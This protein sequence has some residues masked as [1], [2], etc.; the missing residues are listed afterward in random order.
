MAEAAYILLAESGE[1]DAHEKIRKCTLSCE[2]NKT[3]LKEELEKDPALWT[4][5]A[6]GLSKSLA[7]S[8]EEFF[9]RPELYRGRSA[10]KAK[11]IAEKYSLLEKK[12]SEALHAH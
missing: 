10:V 2:E 12:I 11:K 5:I 8:P 9:S 3:S 1:T 7:V 6:S 4:G